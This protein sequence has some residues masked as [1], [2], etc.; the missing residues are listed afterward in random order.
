MGDEC[1][2]S[3]QLVDWVMRAPDGALAQGLYPA[4]EASA[5]R[6]TVTI[7]SL[8][9]DGRFRNG[10]DTSVRLISLDGRA[11]EFTA[12]QSAPGRYT[13]SIAS[14]PPGVYEV[15][16]EQRQA[17]VLEASSQASLVVPARAEFRSIEP[18][19]ATLRRTCGGHRRRAY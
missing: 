8:D 11:L 4:V 14:P 16:I 5:E 7:D 12:G 13:L 9:P 2:L 17:G 3:A 15:Q 1:R 19:I 10:L 18:D 6:T